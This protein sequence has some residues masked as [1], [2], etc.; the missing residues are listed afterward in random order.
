MEYKDNQIKVLKELLRLYVAFEIVDLDEDEFENFIGFLN[1]DENFLKTSSD[2]ELI[3]FIKDKF[4][5]FQ[6]IKYIQG[7]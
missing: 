6:R 2:L 1:V 5:H 4:E 3:T 7:R